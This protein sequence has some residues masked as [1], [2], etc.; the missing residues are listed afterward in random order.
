MN[1]TKQGFTLIELLIVI[2][3]IGV[4]A[5]VIVASLLVAKEKARD[6]KRI[7][8]I[9]EIQTAL[10]SYYTDHGQYPIS[11]A[12][13]VP[14]WEN[15]CYSAPASI[16]PLLVS[17]GYYPPIKDPSADCDTHWGY[18]YGSNGNDYKLLAHTE[19]SLPSIK[20][21]IDPSTDFGT[22][23]CII[24]GGNIEHFGVWT[25]GAT[26]WVEMTTPIVIP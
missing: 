9:K 23:D 19:Y 24:D 22:D 13:S 10:E 8:E 20:S 11:M 21:M 2:A 18:S 25:Q 17:E 15:Q 4:L 3:I 6:T 16:I 12:G 5:A 7:S 26:C 1:K 14:G